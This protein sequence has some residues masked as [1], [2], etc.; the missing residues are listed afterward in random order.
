NVLQLATTHNELRHFLSSV[1]SELYNLAA[2]RIYAWNP[3]AKS[4]RAGFLRLPN[5]FD[6]LELEPIFEQFVNKP[7]APN[8]EFLLDVAISR[9]DT[10][11]HQLFGI[12]ADEGHGNACVFDILN[13]LRSEHRPFAR[14]LFDRLLEPWLKQLNESVPVPHVS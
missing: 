10:H 2:R 8:H 3:L 11:G 12:R 4:L 13:R 7:P 1:L 9:T 6:I 14:R 5:F